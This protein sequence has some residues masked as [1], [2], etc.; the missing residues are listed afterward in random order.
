MLKHRTRVILIAISWALSLAAMVALVALGQAITS[1]IV[2]AA[3]SA[4]GLLTPALADA[5]VV[6]R[7]RVTPGRRAVGDDV[8]PDA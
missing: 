5:I 1:P 7:R 8:S 6:E 4:F 2:V 3:S